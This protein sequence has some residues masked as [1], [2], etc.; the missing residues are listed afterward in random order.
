M[1]LEHP[2]SLERLV[3][4][5]KHDTRTFCDGLG[6]QYHGILLV[7]LLPSMAKLL[8]GNVGRQSG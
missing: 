3:P 4:T 6:Q 7:P 8:Q 1:F 5:V 2:P